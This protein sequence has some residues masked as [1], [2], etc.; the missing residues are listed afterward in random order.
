[1]STKRAQ[2]AFPMQRALPPMANKPFFELARAVFLAYEDRIV[3]FTE[4]TELVPGIKTRLLPGHT[5]GHTGFEIADGDDPLLF[6]GD[7]V[8]VEAYQLP[9]PE[10]TIGFDLDADQAR[11]TRLTLL[12]EMVAKKHRIAGMHLSFPGI[13]RVAKEGDGYRFDAEDWAFAV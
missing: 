8:H 4:E 11:E 6:W 9:R 5:P 3:P 12:P 1:S 2:R 7:I 13:G 10:L